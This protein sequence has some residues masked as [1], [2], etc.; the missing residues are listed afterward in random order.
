V[1][2]QIKNLAADI[3]EWLGTRP[4]ITT[5]EHILEAFANHP[6]LHSKTAMGQYQSVRYLLRHSTMF[7]ITTMR[8]ANGRKMV[9]SRSGGGQ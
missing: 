7:T 5:M 4:R 3:W 9:I 8:H 1:S 2:R 6:H